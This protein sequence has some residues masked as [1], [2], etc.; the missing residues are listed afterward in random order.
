MKTVVF[1]LLKMTGLALLGLA[2]VYT[3]W[4]P[5]FPSRFLIQGMAKRIDPQHVPEGVQKV[6]RFELTGKGGGV[7]NFVVRKDGVEVVEG[8]TDQVDL[9]L[10]IEARKFNDLIFSFA[11]GEASSNT[12]LRLMISKVMRTAGDM[13]VLG[14]IFKKTGANG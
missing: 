1:T 7:Y 5:V 13:E 2:L 6:V 4:E 12:F 9:V 14:L 8:E 10:F 11:R 3:L